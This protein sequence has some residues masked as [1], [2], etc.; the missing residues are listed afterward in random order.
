MKFIPALASLLLLGSVLAHADDMR[1]WTNTK[2]VK[3][4]GTVVSKTADSVTLKMANGKTAK[5]PLAQLSTED[6]DFVVQWSPDAAPDSKKN[7]DKKTDEGGENYTAEWP[8]RIA[9]PVEIPA[10]VISESDGKYIYETEHFRFESDAK[11]TIAVIRKLSCMFEATFEANCQLPLN[12]SCRHVKASP[13]EHKFV[14]KLYEHKSDFD[15]ICPL[16]NVAGVYIPPN[17]HVPFVS[18]GLKQMGSAYALDKGGDVKTLIHE[19]THQMS[20]GKHDFPMW[21]A[22]GIAEY[23]GMTPYNSGKFNFGLTKKSLISYVTQYGRRNSGGRGL[24]KDISIP[25]L[26]V[27]MNL[28]HEDF[29]SNGQRN[30]GVSALLAY[31]FIALDGKKD[32]A[33]LKE[34]VKQLGVL[35]DT[36]KKRAE[37]YAAKLLK[38]G[39]PRANAIAKAQKMYN[40]LDDGSAIAKL[41]D[42]RS[43]EELE[44][45]VQKGLKQ[46]TVDISFN[47][48]A[49]SGFDENE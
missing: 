22:E 29:M 49:P 11:L 14:A 13:K 23:V 17:I 20:L 19:I 3:I 40:Q 2:G 18:L 26:K 27:F 12:F 45:E 34:Y 4:Q 1:T 32:G 31:Y 38:E 35:N 16:E 6:V 46:M 21:L 24:G 48:A 30:Y 10:E 47:A 43:W 36:R 33:R 39:T 44:K 41:Q 7:D 15:K 9:V 25:P 8:N 5:I 37:E 28:S 42:G